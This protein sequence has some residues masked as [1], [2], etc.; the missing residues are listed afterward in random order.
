MSKKM[1]Y[2]TSVAANATVASIFAGQLHEFCAGNS[3][4]DVIACAAAQGLNISVLVG[5]ETF[6]KTKLS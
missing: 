4:I 2:N 6:A 3:N 5:N 1:T